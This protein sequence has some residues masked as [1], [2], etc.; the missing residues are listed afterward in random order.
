[1]KI[2]IFT[3]LW[4]NYG[5]LLQAYSLQRTLK[6]MFPQNEVIMLKYLPKDTRRNMAVFCRKS[7]NPIIDIFWQFCTF[8]RYNSLKIRQ[9]AFEDFRNRYM[10]FTNVYESVS[11]V[12]SNPPDLDIYISGSDQV[13]NPKRRARDI[14]YLNFP[15]EGR[16]KIAYAP[17]FGIS[18]LTQSD[19]DYIK[20]C[21]SDFDAVSCRETDGS[22]LMSKMLGKDVPTVLDP[23][24]LTS[25]D[26]WRLIAKKPKI[27]G[28]YV[29]IYSLMKSAEI[30]SLCKKLPSEYLDC[31]II[32]LSPHDMRFYMKC[33][34]LYSPGPEEFLGLIDNAEL[35]LTDS[36]HGTAFSIIF[37][38]KFCTC[39]S[40]P[41]YGTRIVS[42]L[43]QLSAEDRIIDRNSE[44]LEIRGISENSYSVL[45]HLA[46]LSLSYLEQS[47]NSY[48]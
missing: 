10:D 3:F 12:T 36:F 21:I 30:L 5:A 17:S 35:V 23:V 48:L 42:L 4:T 15:K 44:L 22:H 27:S 9:R 45:S 40:Q 24:F 2:G 47:I 8:F 34:H 46:E 20:R 16:V 28:R 39:I 37:G 14:Y 31:K 7:A 41:K 13:F 1:M 33:K 32:L 11:A 18:V 26:K 29:F 38:K 25:P 6:E 43:S 19:Q